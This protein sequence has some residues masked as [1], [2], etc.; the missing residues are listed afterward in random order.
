MALDKNLLKNKIKNK[1]SELKNDFIKNLDGSFSSQNTNTQT[2]YQA[3]LNI[4]ERG[5]QYAKM[6]TVSE[7]E[8]R[9]IIS[10]EYANAIAHQIIDLLANKISEIISDEIDNYIRKMEIIIPPGQKVSVTL[11]TKDL[12]K[13]DEI[14]V[15]SLK[16]EIILSGQTTENS[17][18][19]III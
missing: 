3:L 15:S 14:E 2:L 12:I 4:K 18:K 11:F 8:F 10:N 1:I 6:D 17:P 13:T 9:Q 5:S 16:K 7:I 19:A